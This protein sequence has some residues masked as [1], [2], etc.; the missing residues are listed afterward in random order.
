MAVCRT[1]VVTLAVVVAAMASP[2]ASGLA[3]TRLIVVLNDSVGDPASVAA[4]HAARFS[5]AVVHVYRHALKGYAASFPGGALAALAKDPRVAYV[6]LDQTVSAVATQSGAPWGLD[7]IDQRSLPLN[8]NYVYTNTGAGVDAYI[9]DTGIRYTHTQFGGRAVKG[10]DAVVPVGDASDCNGHG[11]H[12][13]GTVGGTTYGVAKQ[14]TLISVR[15]LDCLGSGFT[16]QVIGGVDW[17]TGDHAAGEPA[18]ANMSLGGGPSTALDGAV[19]RSIQDGISYTL[20][21]GNGDAL[22]RPESACNTSP[23]R[24]AEGMT[25][26]ATD[27]SDTK[28]SFANFGSCVDWFAPGVGIRSASWTSDTSTATLSG[29]SMAAPHTAGVAALYLQSSPAAS[30]SAVRAALYNLTT[31]SV[32]RSSSTAN[33]HLLYTNL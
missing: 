16:S 19:R 9:I 21:A 15:V 1:L 5:G 8:G 4:E 2:A 23:A 10:Y 20:A 30:P 3:P 14:V 12:V 32:V 26:S 28:A 18:V 24:V 22:G 7:R 6:E 33:N 27:K 29:T 17:A 11:T 13:A 25:I 31:K